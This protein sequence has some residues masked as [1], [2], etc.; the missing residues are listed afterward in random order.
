MSE[1]IRS[2]IELFIEFGHGTVSVGMA[3][4]KPLNGEAPFWTVMLGSL[5][6]SYPL[7][8]I[9]PDT[10]KEHPRDR[11]FLSYSSEDRAVKAA[12]GLVGSTEE[13]MWQ[14]WNRRKA[15]AEA[16]AWTLSVAD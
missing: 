7:G 8:D 15:E 2:P 1:F 6:R 5:S 13:N 4:H 14:R 9:P 11:V 16:K 3:E 10:E 12:A